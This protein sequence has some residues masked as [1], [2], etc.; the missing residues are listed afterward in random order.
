[1][2]QFD[3]KTATADEL[4]EYCLKEYQSRNPITK[5]LIDNFFK[6]IERL[7]SKLEN[8]DKVLDVGCGAG[9]SSREIGALFKGKHFEVSEYDERYI[10]KLKET[11]FPYHITQESIYSLKRK[12]N[13]FGCVFLLEVL[14]HLDNVD[15]ALKELFRVS[16]RYVLISV[17]N[18]PLWRILNLL[19]LKYIRNFGNTPGH[20]NHWSPRKL[21]SL[22]SAYGR[23]M[24]ISLPIPWI[25]V[26]AE[27]GK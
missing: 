11:G 2:A 12:D 22:I 15:L 8:V 16:G 27:T 17:P 13:E 10:T 21:K 1:M 26:L 24:D 7:V 18:E 3:E 5:F 4:W 25:L 14:E 19:R 23:V 6:K 20:I 9:E